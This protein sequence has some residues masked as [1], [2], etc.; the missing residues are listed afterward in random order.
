MD[1]G[2]PKPKK[3]LEQLEAE[4]NKITILMGG[5]MYFLNLR[6]DLESELQNLVTIWDDMEE[7]KDL[8]NVLRGSS[9]FKKVN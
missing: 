2:G 5:L 1:E 7:G 6:I 8:K 9:N 3:S 4:Y